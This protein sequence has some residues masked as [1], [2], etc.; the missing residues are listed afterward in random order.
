MLFWR[1]KATLLAILLITTIIT[2]TNLK[3]AN[4]I[5]TKTLEDKL[6]GMWL[7]QLI[8]NA[9]GRPYE[10]GYQWGP[11]PDPCVPWVIK[12]EWDADDDTDIEYIAMHIIEANGLDCN[13]VD[14]ANQWQE[15]ITT[16]GIY[17]SNKQAWH[18]MGDGFLPPQ[19]GSR[20][21]NEHWYSI[22]SQITTEFLGAI[23]PGMPQT[24]INLAGKFAHVSNDGFPVHAAQLYASMYAY[25]FFEPNVVNLVNAGLKTIPLSS[26]THEVAKDVLD[27]Y[28]EDANDGTLD[29]RG[30]RLK[31]RDKY[32]GTD[33][34]GRYYFWIEST[35]NTGA[36][37]LAILYGQGDFKQT[38]QIGVLA[39]WDN[40]CNPAHAAGLIGIINGY[41]GL[42][43][44]LTDPNICGDVYKNV[45]RPYLPDH[46]IY[47]PQYD[48]IT[49]IASRLTDIAKQN[50]IN[51]SGW[52]D[53]NDPNFYYIPDQN[54]IITEPEKP[55]PNGP[56]GLVADAINASI[57][58]TA[59]AAVE[60]HDPDNDRYNLDAI[61]DGIKDNSYNG[62]RPYWS[63]SATPPVKDWYQL[64][65]AK[66]VKFSGITFYEGDRVWGNGYIYYKNDIG[67][68]GF[69]EDL[70]VQILKDGKY[71]TPANLQMLTP[72]DQYIMY[73]QIDFTFAPTVGDAIRIIGR[74]GGTLNYTTIMELEAQGDISTGL[75]VESVNINDG[76]PYRSKVD[77]VQFKFN[78]FANIVKENIDISGIDSGI[79]DMN[80]VSFEYNSS[81]HWTTLT[82]TQPLQ[83]DRYE[84]K[85]DCADITDANGLGL[86][87]DDAIDLD[88]L[89]SIEFHQLFGDSDGSM[90]IDFGDISAFAFLWLDVPQDSGLDKNND[91]IINLY[92]LSAVVKNWLRGF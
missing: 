66:P 63:F 89:Y 14:I 4:T 2:L 12:L 29:W 83:D 27:W 44:D 41:S 20:A 3:A 19:T 82:F 40:D 15:H 85:L 8:G 65:F 78:R 61:I 49:N 67:R 76:Q 48:T 26:R 55:D 71:V 42:P 75:Y 36:T 28:T 24:A 50:I 37:I 53:A 46:D 16:S 23:S 54:S 92:D 68:G 17:V 59:S 1:S 64:N 72:L 25:A 91:N 86:L 70:S 18:L 32:F 22:D 81:T 9:A 33:S 21:Y 79:I 60:T 7:G 10:G 34:F 38:A 77:K 51:N 87:D 11:I 43:P 35:V 73:Q 31:L 84:L 30:T 62:H 52:Q 74:P 45:Y 57:A 6:H 13:Y 69:F 88:G 56:G 80:E 5:S 39:G 90:L 58:V 47:L